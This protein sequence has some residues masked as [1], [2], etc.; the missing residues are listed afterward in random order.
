VTTAAGTG[1]LHDGFFVIAFPC[2]ANIERIDPDGGCQ[3]QTLDVTLELSWC[4]LGGDV[5][6]VHFGDGVAVNAFDRASP[7]SV[8]ASISVAADAAI[9]PRNVWIVTTGG[10]V[11]FLDGFFTVLP[12]CDLTEVYILPAGQTVGAGGTFTVDVAVDPATAIAGAQLN[13]GFDP[14]LLSANTVTEGNLL[15]QGGAP[16]LFSCSGG[17]PPGTIDNVAGTIANVYGAILQAGGTVS[18]PGTFATI[19]LTAKPK[20]GNSTLHLWNVLVGDAAGHPVAVAV[21]DGSV[22]VQPYPDWEVNQDG[23]IDVLDIIL[24]GQHFGETGPLC[25]IREDVNCDGHI[26]VL[27]IILIG[28]HFGEGCP[29]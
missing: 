5:L 3:G 12:A 1:T 2:A 7:Y 21:I 17:C 23:C 11:P 27:D 16:T 14:S 4:C 20:A 26:S 29:A 6:D 13:L 28:Q 18:S 9:G 22:T 15:K 10:I 24:V 19:T 25:W 8:V